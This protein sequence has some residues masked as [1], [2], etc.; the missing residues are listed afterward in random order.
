MKPGLAPKIALFLIPALLLLTVGCPKE[1]AKPGGTTEEPTT[2]PFTPFPGITSEVVV[3]NAAVP[4]AL[5][6]APDGRLFYN[7]RY[8]GN[9]RIVTP[10]GQP[11]KE[12]FV[13]VEVD[14]TT[15]A[16]GLVGIALDPQF[17][18]ASHRY[19]YV[20]YFETVGEP[21]DRVA[22]PVVVRFTDV[23]NHG[24]DPKVI[25]G[26]LPKAQLDEG[27]PV[28]ALGFGPDGDLYI[29]IGDNV[30]TQFSQDLS[31]VRGKILRVSKEDG[32]APPD[33]PFAGQSDADPRIFAYGFLH[34]YDFTFHAQTGEMY[35]SEYGIYFCCD[36]I[37]IVRAGGN[38]S[39]P[40]IGLDQSGIMPFY[41]FPDQA[42]VRPAG[43]QFVSGDV[44]PA[45]GDSL[46]VC[47][48][49]DSFMRHLVLSG[50]NHDQVESDADIIVDDCNL[51]I[52]TSPDGVLYYAND[53]E[54]RRLVVGG[55]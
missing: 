51:D 34:A 41:F 7:E 38:Y 52:A 13:H 39:R 55:Q 54:I 18:T 4:V 11:L 23:D 49:A 53:T 33:N 16:W 42:S 5:A 35:A 31:S 47:Q 8:T 2:P 44:Y 17:E 48:A 30:F 14:P 40:E 22:K 1:A 6:F 19:V 46:L 27:Y 15:L 45:L 36:E 3:P 32:S 43:I 29:T 9:V 10:D 28:S 37:D 21:E 25:V 26:D 50:P 12:P 20:A 24:T